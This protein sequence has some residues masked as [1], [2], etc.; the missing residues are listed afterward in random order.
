ML[1]S[2]YSSS[3]VRREEKE[4]EGGTDRGGADPGGRVLAL[5]KL[6]SALQTAK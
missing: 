6:P 3:G 1:A 5:S 2:R 4:G